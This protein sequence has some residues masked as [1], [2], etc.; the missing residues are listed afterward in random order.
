MGPRLLLGEL[1]LFFFQL[2]SSGRGSVVLTPSRGK[3]GAWSAVALSTL[4]RH[5]PT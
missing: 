1:G 4:R 2:K 3:L 5:A